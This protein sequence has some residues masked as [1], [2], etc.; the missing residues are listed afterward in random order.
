MSQVG[1]E[2]PLPDEMQGQWVDANDPSYVVEICGGEVTYGGGRSEYDWKKI[3]RQDDGALVVEFGVDDDAQ[4]DAFAR[5]SVNG[6]AMTPDG[7]FH[8]WNVKFACQLVRP[9]SGD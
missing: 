8:M 7:E 2:A 5:Q 6:L 9:G 1:R 4:D 3:T